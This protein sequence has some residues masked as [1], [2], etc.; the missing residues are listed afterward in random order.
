MTEQKLCMSK[1][2]DALVDTCT[3]LFLLIKSLLKEKRDVILNRWDVREG[4]CWVSARLLPPSGELQLFICFTF[5]A[6][7]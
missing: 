6:H 2:G 7:F 1:P 5:L 4:E 3:A